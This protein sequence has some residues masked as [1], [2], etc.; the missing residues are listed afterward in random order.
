[1][2][3]SRHLQ[4]SLLALLDLRYLRET[5]KL[6]DLYSD[7]SLEIAERK[8]NN[9][10]MSIIMKMNDKI[11]RPIFVQLVDWATT[12]SSEDRK[13]EEC[14]MISFF[15]FYEVLNDQLKVRSCFYY[16]SYRP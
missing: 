11:F 3:N 13:A 12:P 16:T 2:K 4:Q 7:S 8:I 1:M 5:E 14:K 15:K 10:A 6:Q 9:L